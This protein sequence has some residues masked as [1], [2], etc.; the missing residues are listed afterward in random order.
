MQ[1]IKSVLIKAL[2]RA[3]D[4]IELGLCEISDEE[5]LNT[6]SLFAHRPL[7]KEQACR[8]LNMSRA[9]FDKKVKLGELPRGRKVVG[10]KELR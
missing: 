1:E 6:I 5:A 2:R 10:Y 8:Y 4:D 7:S 9:T 3:A